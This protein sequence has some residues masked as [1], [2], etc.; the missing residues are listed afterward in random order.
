MFF[1][2]HQGREVKRLTLA[3]VEYLVG[4]HAQSA[5][6]PHLHPHALRH[7]ATSLAANFG[8]PLHRIRDRMGHSSALITSH[9]LHVVGSKAG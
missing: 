2:D 4:L 7:T 1:G 8:E 3:S 9:Y 5:R 6:I